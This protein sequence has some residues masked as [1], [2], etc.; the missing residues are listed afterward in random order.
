MVEGTR[1]LD[2]ALFRGSAGKRL[3]CRVET[4]TIPVLAEV[5]HRR[6][7]LGR[8]RIGDHPSSSTKRR[9]FGCAVSLARGSA[10]R[11]YSRPLQARLV[12]PVLHASAGM[13][14]PRGCPWV[15]STAETDKRCLADG[16]GRAPWG[17][18][19]ES[20]LAAEAV[21]LP[22]RRALNEGGR[23]SG[24]G[25]YGTTTRTRAGTNLDQ[26][27]ELAPDQA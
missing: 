24:L 20:R 13:E 16:I 26:S 4:R 11:R 1:L 17:P 14:R 15:A 23:L 8:G 3:G 22:G 5:R 27:W 12:T 18:D 6:R 21:R 10:T 25:K 9:S 2:G 19:E 7:V